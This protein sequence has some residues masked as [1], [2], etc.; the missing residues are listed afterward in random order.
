MPMRTR[1]RTRTRGGGGANR[2]GL[3]SLLPTSTGRHY[4]EG[5]SVVFRALDEDNRASIVSN[6]PGG[7]RKSDRANL[8]WP[9]S[10]RIHA[11]LSV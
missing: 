10:T 11:R 2:K 9:A 7:P 5:G 4:V 6:M 8:I 3:N 1:T